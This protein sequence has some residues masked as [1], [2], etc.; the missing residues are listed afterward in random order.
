[1]KKYPL[2]TLV[3]ALLLCASCTPTPEPTPEPFVLEER[4]VKILVNEVYSGAEGEN[5]LDF[6]ELFN[7]GT[8]IA[9]LNGY[10]LWYQL[11]EGD[12]E[13]LI[14]AWSETTLVPPLGFYALGQDGQDFSAVPDLM[15]NQP[16]VP[17][18]GSLSLRNGDQV[19]DQL[20]WGS[21]AEA[22]SEG[23]LA[24]A[25]TP[26]SSLVRVLDP[27]T[28]FPQ[29]TDDNQTDFSLSS[30]PELQNTGS[31]ILHPAGADL[32]FSFQ[33]PQLVRPGEQ[34]EVE[35]E[36]NNQT[37]FEVVDPVLVLPLP[38][39][40][41]LQEGSTGFELT[42][43]LLSVS[44][45]TLAAGETF[46]G[47]I[48]LEG[49]LTFSQF[50]IHNIYLESDSWPLAAFAGPVYGEI[51]GGPIPIATARD[52]IDQEVV[53][54]GIATMYVGGFYA[55]SGA[56]FYL[57]DETAGL[58]VYVSGAGNSLV[59]PLGSRLQVRGTIQVYRD[60]IELV[61]SS[62]DQVEV[63]AGSSEESTI[64]PAEVEIVQ[65][66]TAPQDLPG[67][68]IVVEG[69]IARIEEFSYSFEIDLFDDSGNL[70]NIYIDKNTG[71]SIEEIEADQ[72]YQ[73]TGIMELLDGNYRLYPR[74][75][76][77]LVRVYE[78]GLAVQ[79]HPPTTAIPGEPFQ[80]TYTLI[81]HSPEPDQNLVVSAWVD[82]ALEILEVNDLGRFTGNRVIWDR[83][84]IAGDETLNLTYTAKIIDDVEFVTYDDYLAISTAWPVASNGATSYTFTG[85]SVP[86]WAVQGPEARS[87]Y[88]LS[89]LTTEG[90]V[91]GVFPELEGF[92]IQEKVS[93][94]DPDTSP[95]L[96]VRSGPTLP[97]VTPGDLVAVTGRIRE[98][99]SQTELEINS[100]TNVEVTGRTQ[101]P[102]PV[103]LDPPLDNEASALY[104]ESLEGCL[105]EVEDWAVVVGPTTRYGEFAVVQEEDGVTRSFQDQANGNLIFVDDGSAVTHDSADTLEYRLSVGDTVLGLQGP[106]AYT[107]GNYKIQPTSEYIVRTLNPELEPLAALDESYL[108][109]MTWN[110]ENLFDFVVPH[111]SSPPLPT[112]R[113]YKRD[114]TKVALTVEAAGFPT[115]IG[116]QEVENL[117]ILEDIAEEPLLADFE[118]QAVLI[119]GTDSRGIDVGYLVRGD[120]AIVLDQVQYPA[121]GNIT[122]RPPLLIKIEVG[123]NGE[124]I[125]ILNNHFTSMSGGEEATEPRRNAQAAWNAEIVQEL[126]GEDPNA[127]VVVMG[128][129]NSYYGSLPI[130][131]LEES[132][133]INL[134]DRLLPEER[135]TYV[136]QGNSQV[137]DHILVNDQ[138]LNYLVSFEVL[139]S[140]ADYSLPLSTDTSLFHKSDHDPVIATFVL[141]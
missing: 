45:P 127:L 50:S 128:D 42:G 61:P 132:G 136:Y 78:P 86:I 104:Y 70:V 77:D 79:V 21:G 84:T 37:G 135:Y 92:W 96:F 85:E 87:P 101:L 1:M 41:F 125:Y 65:I 108:R 46:Q 54:E 76:S 33:F 95:C 102:D 24:P 23:S 44:I 62:E 4:P 18:R 80:V 138:L 82:P 81:N 12:Q 119:E 90:V 14:K 5:Q 122:S 124:K 63:L 55:G 66:N 97:E 56:K 47:Q 3:I 109:L 106:L 35:F 25:M 60:T 110:V 120:Q 68:L 51:G 71:I 73:I 31:P 22:M 48:P 27:E 75:Q 117:E 64:L 8:E 7:A 129:L 49:E 15:I 130:Q 6:I 99:F 113:E 74:L 134:F 13:I 43:N 94:E 115:V 16:L 126:L 28:S 30:A 131:T 9:D 20:A 123:D 141:P 34:F 2:F 111:P 116:F 100:P 112:V 140:N 121:P 133:L 69:R 98:S 26:G 36:L 137:L 58:Q 103:I 52:L 72:R 83:S 88:I 114:I 40:I 19:E 91:T 105:V 93:D 53:V 107:Y 89:N 67:R 118:Y 139:H 38:E 57:E 39:N 29:D 17:T 32:G 11:K 10:S 59:V